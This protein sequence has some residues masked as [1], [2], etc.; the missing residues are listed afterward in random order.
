MISGWKIGEKNMGMPSGMRRLS[1]NLG[2]LEFGIWVGWEL[3]SH[4]NPRAWPPP[5][6]PGYPN[7]SRDEAAAD[8]SEFLDQP[9]GIQAGG[10]CPLSQVLGLEFSSPQAGIPKDS[11]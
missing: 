2:I 8:S 7:N 11:P 1:G 4:P 9:L 10:P 5:T 3:K 6:I